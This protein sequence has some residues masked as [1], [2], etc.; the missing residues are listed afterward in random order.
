MASATFTRELVMEPGAST[1]AGRRLMAVAKGRWSVAHRSRSYLAPTGSCEIGREA[2]RTAME[3]LRHG[4]RDRQ[5]LISH[6]N[7][8]QR[9]SVYLI[10][11]PGTADGVSGLSLYAARSDT[12]IPSKLSG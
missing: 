6:V 9:R 8:G 1:A 4:N 12:Q 11:W 5:L 7:N 2:V 3:P 10:F